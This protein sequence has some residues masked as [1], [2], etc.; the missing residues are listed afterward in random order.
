MTKTQAPQAAMIGILAATALLGG[1]LGG[2]DADALDVPLVAFTLESGFDD[3]GFHWKAVGGDL[4]GQINPVLRI[5]SG[6]GVEIRVVHGSNPADTAPHNIRLALDGTPVA[7]SDDVKAPGD[8]AVLQ[9]APDSDGIFAYLC[10]YHGFGQGA[11]L[12]AGDLELP[13]PPEP[14]PLPAPSPP[15]PPEPA[16]YTLVSHYDITTQDPLAL[17]TL[18][19]HWKSDA[20]DTAGQLDPDLEG[21]VGAPVSL[22]V[23]HGG[24]LGDLQGHI[25]AIYQDG[26]EVAAAP[27]VNADGEATLDWTPPGPGAYTYACKNHPLMG[28]TISVGVRVITLES[29]NTGDGYQWEGVGGA[30]GGQDNPTI[31]LAVNETL[32]IVYR[33]GAGLSDDQVHALRIRD[34]EKQTLVD[35]PDIAAAGDEASIE[36]VPSKPGT[37]SYECKYHPETQ[38]GTI[39]VA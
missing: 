2:D 28:G 29:K 3:E 31:G 12:V 24:D 13:A 4:D 23:R 39:Q 19:L 6:H 27:E 36:W 38:R 9:W 21:R 1:C 20:G 18:N 33:H 5:P 25:L 37:Y 16:A 7:D 8:E 35:G 17:P 26:S 34:A 22:T 14:E 32:R 15:A 30:A 11:E 10:K